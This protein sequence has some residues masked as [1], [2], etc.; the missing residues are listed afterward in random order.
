[1]NENT[2]NKQ[3]YEV[4]KTGETLTREWM[5][6]IIILMIVLLKQRAK[7]YNNTTTTKLED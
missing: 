4:F 6:I 2:E 3:L 5:D 1:M 7:S